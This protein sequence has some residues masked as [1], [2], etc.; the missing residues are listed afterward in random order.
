MH[1][2]LVIMIRIAGASD[3]IVISAMACIAPEMFSFLV[4]SGIDNAGVVGADVMGVIGEISSIFVCAMANGAAA[5]IAIMIKEI[6]CPADPICIPA[7]LSVA[8]QR[9]VSDD[10]L[11]KL[12]V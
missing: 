4:K 5:S 8:P 6:V 3:T 2:K 7:F 11:L 12:F 9:F 10:Y 1:V